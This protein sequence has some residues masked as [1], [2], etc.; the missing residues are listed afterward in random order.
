VLAEATRGL[1][2]L[3]LRYREARRRAQIALDSGA[4]GLTDV[5]SLAVRSMPLPG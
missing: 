5:F 1:Q 4:R 3:G 2:R